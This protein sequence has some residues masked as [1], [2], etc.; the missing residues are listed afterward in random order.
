MITNK[1]WSDINRYP[2]MHCWRSHIRGR[3][4]YGFGPFTEAVKA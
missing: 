1:I 2:G 3:T 4:V